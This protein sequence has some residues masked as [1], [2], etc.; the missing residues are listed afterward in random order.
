[1]TLSPKW[2]VL[3]MS[4]LQTMTLDHARSSWTDV[5]QWDIQVFLAIVIMGSLKW[6]V[7]QFFGQL[8]TSWRCVAHNK[9][10]LNLVYFHLNNNANPAYDY[11]YKFYLCSHKTMPPGKLHT[12][13][14]VIRVWLLQKW[15]M[16]AWA[17]SDARTGYMWNLKMCIG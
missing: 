8:T 10:Q 11:L 5:F 13:H 1:M 17:L 4:E 16:N 2:I 7:L 9:F 12:T 6:S 14:T 3:L 15:G